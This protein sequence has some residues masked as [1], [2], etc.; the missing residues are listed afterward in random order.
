MLS[1]DPGSLKKTRMETSVRAKPILAENIIFLGSDVPISQAVTKTSCDFVKN[2]V[3]L[4][5]KY[6]QTPPASFQVKP[7]S[8]FVTRLIFWFQEASDSIIGVPQNLVNIDSGE[9]E[10]MYVDDR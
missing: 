9:K 4:S 5:E 2:A 8:T 7:F 6:L 10:R 3:I 1:S